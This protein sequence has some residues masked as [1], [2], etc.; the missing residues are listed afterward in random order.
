M[1]TL[2]YILLSVSLVSALSLAGVVLLALSATTLQ[3][4]MSAAIAFAAG[5]ML[6][7]AFLDLIP[8]ALSEVEGGHAFVLLGIIAFF[9]VERAIH[10]HH[11][12]EVHCIAP[13]GYLNLIGDAAHN[14]A[15]G[16]IIAAA[17][18]SGTELGLVTTVAIAM[19]ELPQELG[20]YAVLLHSGFTPRRAVWLNFLTAL[21]AVAGGL[22][23]YLFLSQLTWLVPYAVL[24]AAGG[25]IY[26]AVADLMPELHKERRLSRVVAHTG[27]LLLGIGLIAGFMLVVPHG[28][29]HGHGH[30][31]HEG[32][33]MHE[34]TGLHEGSWL[35]EEAETAGRATSPHG[36]QAESQQNGRPG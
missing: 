9:L 28:H 13:A 29:G 4:L 3:R 7:A 34:E 31:G 24:V 5:T 25:L 36:F 23:G 20:D 1:G 15:D 18:L 21:T 12:P 30:E 27:S 19:H 6:G 32:T 35:R 16:V 11:C 33:G 10:W 8:E 14:F 26:I 22:G 2:G 17:F